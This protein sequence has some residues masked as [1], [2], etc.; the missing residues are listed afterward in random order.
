MTKDNRV[1]EAETVAV[2]ALRLDTR[3]QLD[4]KP[5]RKKPRSQNRINTLITAEMI[6]KIIERTKAL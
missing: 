4:E 6:H 5:V 2:S 1:F 3:A